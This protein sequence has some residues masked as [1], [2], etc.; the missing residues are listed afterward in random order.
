M[1]RSRIADTDLATPHRGRAI[2]GD[3]FDEMSDHEKA[4]IDILSADPKSTDDDIRL[5]APMPETRAKNKRRRF[6]KKISL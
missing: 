1:G 3:E 2:F 6:I 5:K 4:N